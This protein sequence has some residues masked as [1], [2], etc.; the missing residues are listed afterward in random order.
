MQFN[1]LHGLQKEQKKKYVARY[2]KTYSTSQAKPKLGL[3]I[4]IPRSIWKLKRWKHCASV[5]NWKLMVEI[6][7]VN[8][9]L[10]Y[11]FYVI[12]KILNWS[13]CKHY[14]LV[15][16]KKKLQIRTEDFT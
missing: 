6:A 8:Y 3:Y 5:K 14:S 9:D 1:M 11:T 15:T 10:D 13:K 2:Q 12:L 4:N 16:T 7:G